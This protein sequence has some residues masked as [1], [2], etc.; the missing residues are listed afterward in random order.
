M[1]SICDLRRSKDKEIKV[2]GSNL[3]FSSGIPAR[4]A[5]SIAMI[6]FASASLDARAQALDLRTEIEP[7]VMRIASDRCIDQERTRRT[8]S[9]ARLSD[10]VLKSIRRPAESMPWHRY[11]RL[12]VTRSRVEKGVEFAR[13]HAE[14]LERADSRFGVPAQ[15]IT[16]IIGIESAYGANRGSHLVLDALATLGFRY[17]DKPKRSDFFR[18]ELESLFLLAC[19]EDIDLLKIKGSYAGA[20]GI[21]QFI[22]SSYRNFAVD[23]DED[24]NRDLVNSWADAIGSIANYL[25]EHGWSADAPIAVEAKV[26]GDAYHAIIA[27][28]IKPSMTVESIEGQGVSPAGKDDALQ[29][30]S[31][32]ALA[33]LLEFEVKGGSEYWLGFDNFYTITRYNHSRLY[34]LA[35]FQLS[36]MIRERIAG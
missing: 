9:A 24:G 14:L 13:K 27:K 20:I 21:P 12:L 1:A 5:A 11:R 3:R 34:A 16:A 6:C 17:P 18:S 28:G 2:L 35:I 10:S 23:F 29:D 8:L 25:A 22:P 4:F 36:E 31:P 19:E 33:A 7:F 26:E 30:E 32:Q 15:I